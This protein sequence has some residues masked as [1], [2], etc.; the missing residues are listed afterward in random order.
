MK[1]HSDIYTNDNTV[2]MYLNGKKYRVTVK[3]SWG[4]DGI[5]NNADV[6]IVL[7]DDP[8]TVG[9]CEKCRLYR[10]RDY[11]YKF[12]GFPYFIQNTVSPCSNEG[13][14]Y[15]YVCTIESGW[16]DSGNSNI[17][18]LIKDDKVLDVYHEASCC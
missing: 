18:I 9:K 2:V 11:D 15:T 4:E 12:G 3:E 8:L 13:V 5:P 1:S 7:T 16:G 14:P 10:G 6:D 17:F